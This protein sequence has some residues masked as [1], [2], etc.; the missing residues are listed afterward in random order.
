M[1]ASDR[2]AING[3]KNL[4]ARSSGRRRHLNAPG[5]SGHNHRY[6]LTIFGVLRV[7]RHQVAL[8]ELD[9][10]QNVRRRDKREE[11]VSHGHNRRAP[12]S[13]EPTYVQWMANDAIEKR[14]REF[15]T[16]LRFP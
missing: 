6:P 8:F 11:H 3:A 16:A 7:R 4:N 15:H 2:G 10:D 14:R 13:E 12:K 9:R 5:H 1:H